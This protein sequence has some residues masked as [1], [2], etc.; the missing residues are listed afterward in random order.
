MPSISCFVWVHRVSG[1][2]TKRIH[3][4]LGSFRDPLKLIPTL[5]VAS[6][7][8]TTLKVGIHTKFEG[9]PFGDQVA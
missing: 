2:M 4:L 5:R 6:F 8:E 9:S 3:P 1:N 7:K